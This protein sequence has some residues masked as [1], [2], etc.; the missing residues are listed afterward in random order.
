M[1]IFIKTL[2]MMLLGILTLS[3][4]TE[5][6]EVTLGSLAGFVTEAPAGTE[7]ISGVTVSI[8]STGQSS[9][10][11]TDG[12]FTFKDLEPGTYSLQLTKTGYT[13]VKKSV[14]VVAGQMT[15]CDLQM[16]KVN[17]VAEIE[18]NPSSIN[19]G[20]TQ[21]D[22]SVTIKN[23][24]NATA[25]WSLN[26]GNNPWLSASQ[27]SGS[28][29]ADR[30]QSI[31]FSVDRS[32]L[33]ETKS[34]IVN[35]QAFGNSYPI[36]VSCAPKNASSSM[37]IDPVILNF[38]SD[39][40][41]LS[42]TIRNTGT[43]PLTWRASQITTPVLSLSATQGTVA[44]GGSSVVLANI[45]RTLVSGEMTSTFI[46][47]DG[48]IDQTM[49]VNINGTSGGGSG[50]G[51]QPGGGS[52]DPGSLVVTNGLAAY[53][54]FNDTY[55]DTMHMYDGFGINDPT[56]ES[57]I[58]GQ[59]VKFNKS[60]ESSVY[61]PYGLINNKTFSVSFWAKNLSD[62]LIFYSKCSD[63]E[64]RFSLSIDG[65]SLKFI[66]SR[67]NNIYQYDKAETKFTHGSIAGD[68]WHHIVL[69]SDYGTTQIYRWT[70]TLYIDGKKTDVITQDSDNSNTG[71]SNMPNAFVI[72]GS[73]KMG[74]TNTLITSNFTIDNLRMY[75]SR[76][77][78]AEEVKEIFN[79]KQ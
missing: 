57:G 8:L 29:Q 21:S 48:V 27:L 4:C 31:T 44:A 41:Q 1:K 20:T 75:D 32:F 77:L 53:Y 55:D 74:S 35:L 49:T 65:G 14:F 73:A 68:N 42:F 64:N 62:G 15:Q 50:S 11:S 39:L 69:V 76:L 13:T 10:T 19:F 25:E 51:D 37:V 30:T 54:Q 58:S 45:D 78:T 2:S 79:A 17:Q 70:T 24:G 23:N 67:Y 16:S 71:D 34:V 22:M 33:S 28:I 38:G 18:I 66:C 7:P 63:N 59:A 43:S 3:S 9:T 47:S 52:D 72:G 56:F 40:S 12:S 26:L 60:K 5:D 6:P 61:I 46:I 36:T